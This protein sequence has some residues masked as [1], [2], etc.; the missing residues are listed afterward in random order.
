MA[1]DPVRDAAVIILLRVLVRGMHLDHALD[2]TLERHSFSPQGR[3]FLTQ[4]VYGVTRHKTLCD[5]VLSGLC[6]RPLDLL[7]A[8]VLMVL[9][10]AIFQSLFC[11]TVT[12][13]AMVHT[14]VELAKRHGHAGLARMVNAIL[15]KAPG[16]LEDVGLPD[17]ITDPVGYLRI[18]YS[19]PRW[20]VRRWFD[21]FG[22]ERTALLCAA[23]NEPAPC[24]IRL[25]TLKG[26]PASLGAR[27]AV[28]GMT[29]RPDAILP[30]A[31]MVPQG[32]DPVRNK[33]F[34]E[35]L[36]LLQD[37]A[38]MLPV[39]L[40]DPAPGESLLDMC[41]APGGK[42]THMAALT[43]D[44]ARITALERV[45]DRIRLIRENTVRL[46]VSSVDA[47]CADAAVPPLTPGSFDRVLVDAPCSGLGTLRRHPELKWRHDPD[48]VT[49]LAG[50][51]RSLLR[52]AV[53]LC[54]NDGVVV[55]SVCTL[56][57]EETF[58]L[59]ETVLSWGT[60]EPEDGPEQYNTWKTSK[61]QY[62]IT[63]AEAA[64][65]GFFLMRFRKR[66]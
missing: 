22:P 5:H 45:Y 14:S 15:R 35:G 28:S 10:L 48:S 17:R 46:G 8:P 44:R 11:H 31:A 66:F 59:V 64:W 13:P 55:Y 58:D 36:Y 25:N 65:D 16:A 24:W 41:A 37:P 29:V 63:P 33:A 38:S 32:T 57:R 27:L 56:T 21:W 39:R 2:K 7:P 40:L 47:V 52:A 61:G 54:K 51:Q 62:L 6:R 1:V 42:S 19:M 49:E 26:D 30:E 23:T 18:R 50:V 12:R 20:L 9:R 43:G 60:C 34:R 3:R 53:Q 4:L